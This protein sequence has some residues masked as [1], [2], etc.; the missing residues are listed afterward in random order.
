VV[1]AP[2]NF[3]ICTHSRWDSNTALTLTP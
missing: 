1:M 2:S 3:G